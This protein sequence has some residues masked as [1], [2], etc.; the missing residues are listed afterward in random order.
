MKEN[1]NTKNEKTEHFKPAFMPIKAEH[2]REQP[3][4]QQKH[5]TTD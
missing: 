5:R 3:N 2:D 4:T 1:F